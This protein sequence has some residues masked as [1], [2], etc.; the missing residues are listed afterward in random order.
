MEMIKIKLCF[1]AGILVFSTLAQANVP[2]WVSSYGLQV[3]YH[4]GEYLTGFGMAAIS[5]GQDLSAVMGQAEANSRQDLISKIRVQVESVTSSLIQE[6]DQEFTS[7]FV[8]ATTST[9][10]LELFGLQSDNHINRSDGYVYVLSRISRS[11]LFDQFHQQLLDVSDSFLRTRQSADTF[12]EDGNYELALEN[13]LKARTLYSEIIE[14]WSLMQSVRGSASIGSAQD[15]SPAAFRD[16]LSHINSSVDRIINRPIST[17]EDAGWWLA[18]T[19]G[20]AS[21]EPVR[22]NVSAITYR[23]SG[24]S[25]EFANYLR[26]L[27][28]RQLSSRTNWEIQGIGH[29]YERNPSHLL[30]GTFWDRGDDIH[31][32]V[33][34]RQTDNGRIFTASEVSIPKSV[35]EQ[36]SL[37]LLPDNYEQAL[38]DLKALQQNEGDNRGLNLSVWT[39]RGEHNLVFEEGDIMEISLQVN[40]PGYVR[41]IYHL[42]DGRRA[43]LLDSH[44]INQRDVNKPYTLPFRFEC[45]PPFGVE[46]MQ[47]IAQSDP[48]ERLQTRMIDGIPFLAED[49]NTF[50]VKTRGFRMIQEENQQAERLLT[51]TTMPRSN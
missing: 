21:G 8:S 10:T 41:I 22:L 30:T 38:A 24:I 7:Q 15:R 39:N 47:V 6:S 31:V 35:V 2:R 13:Y 16:V 36:S 1:I 17:L 40:L 3:P 42:K 25:S 26:H 50:L 11:A 33:Y 46:S 49:L 28:E 18:S 4:Q 37:A 44:Y 20:T 51:I 48:F 32:L 9:A 43:L 19:L 45:V 12:F 34:V 14:V 5:P 29:Q 27:L 23:D